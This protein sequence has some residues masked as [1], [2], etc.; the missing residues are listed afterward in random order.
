MVKLC[1]LCNKRPAT[2]IVIPQL[3]DDDGT[4]AACDECLSEA[5]GM[6]SNPDVEKIS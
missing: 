6:F 5:T 2:H 4:V 3:S 1:G